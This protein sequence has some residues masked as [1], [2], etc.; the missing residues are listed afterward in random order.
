MNDI[1]VSF[2]ILD[3]R[4][5]EE[6]NHC[7]RSIKK[8]ALF[9]HKIIYLDNGGY[10]EHYP[11][12]F[13]E[14]YEDYG[15]DVLI[16]KKNGMGGGYG[17]TDLIRYCDTEYF[18]FVQN[19]QQ[20]ISEIL[21]EHVDYMI[22]LLNNGYHC[23]DLNGDQSNR[24]AWTDRAH[25][26]KTSFF[27]SLGPFP[28][29]GPGLDNVPWNEEYLSHK[30]RDN[31]Y[32]IAH[33]KPTIFKDCGKWSIREAGDGLYKH[34]TDTKIMFIEKTPTYKT[35]VFPPFDSE[36]WELALSGNWPKEGKVP[37]LWIKNVF[38]CWPD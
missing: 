4:K 8:H 28:N 19:D 29:G 6:T 15:I 22:S 20:L 14:N 32:K 37:N 38:K 7:L 18:I 1:K 36:D 35:D 17:Q 27:N 16:R 33:I 9:S 24:G 12:S 11:N 34:R 10:N 21:P 26:M 3:F 13:Y 23:V 5:E 30:F 31:N 2:L 25:F